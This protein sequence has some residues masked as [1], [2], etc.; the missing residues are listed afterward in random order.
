MKTK[1]EL[2]DE[3][4]EAEY[5]YFRKDNEFYYPCEYSKCGNFLLLS[6]GDIEEEL[7]FRIYGTNPSDGL[8]YDNTYCSLVCI[9]HAWQSADEIH[10]FYKY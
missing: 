3:G 8:S 10:G 9:A 5:D 2:M 1:M 4:F 6:D 7:T